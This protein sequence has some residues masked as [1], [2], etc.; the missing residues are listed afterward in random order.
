MQLN[1]KTMPRH[2]QAMHNLLLGYNG[3]VVLLLALFMGLTQQ[4]ILLS[5]TARNFLAGV[6]AMPLP[7][8]WMVG[9]SLAAYMALVVLGWFYRR[10]EQTQADWRYVLFALEIVAC[11]LLMRCLNLAY[12]GVVLLVV[13]DIMHRYEGR[14]QEIL[15]LVAMMGLYFVANYNLA[16]FQLSVVP[17][18][19]Y[20]AYYLP[21]VQAGILAAR[22]VGSSLNIIL[23]VLYM[24]MLLR[25]R[26]EETRRIAELNEELG[27]ANAKLRAYALASERMAE[28]RERN[29]LAREIHDT[30]GHALTGIAAGIDACLVTIDSAPDFTKKQL[31]RIRE[32]ALRGIT[33]VRR[34]VKKLRPDDLEK[35][36]LA[37][38]VQKLTQEFAASSGMQILL[39]APQ[40]P[41]ELREDQEDTIYRIVQ[42][43]ITNANRHG[44]AKH[45]TVVVGLSERQ[46]T[47]SIADDGTGCAEIKEGFGL[48]HMQERLA[49]LHGRLRCWHDNGFVLE[50][51][52]PMQ[53][54]E[55]EEK[56]AERD[57][58]G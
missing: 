6:P 9:G 49:L 29:R 36:P 32:T 42:E 50:A 7:V 24:V 28:T 55:G 35:L 15:L 38:A 30:L 33:D 54:R 1:G 46:L 14:N 23:F 37:E 5:M 21:P 34:S 43:G 17:F 53:Q 18:E 2:L 56:N 58:R 19:A 44:K 52:L 13:A 31:Q 41:S 45:V 47:I 10:L 40:W 25:D 12:D 27:R 11:V 3:L 48:R 20:A 4:K 16:F 57:D 51:T 39:Y 8:S 22:N 26:R